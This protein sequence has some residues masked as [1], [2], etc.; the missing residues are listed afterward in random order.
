VAQ[1]QSRYLIFIF[2]VL[3][4]FVFPLTACHKNSDN[5]PVVQIAGEP[6]RVIFDDA[7]YSQDL[8]DLR[9]MENSLKSVGLKFIS[10]SNG[11]VFWDQDFRK[12]F[13]QRAPRV[14]ESFRHDQLKQFSDAIVGFL[15]KY[16]GQFGLRHQDGSIEPARLPERLVDRLNRKLKL[17]NETI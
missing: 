15:I 5:D 13:E 12:N 1:I 11:A 8:S 14:P 16:S 7:I 2:S 4:A 17:T 6:I 3:F 10:D 9:A